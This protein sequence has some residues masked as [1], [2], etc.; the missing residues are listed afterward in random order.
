MTSW[1]APREGKKNAGSDVETIFLRRHAK[2]WIR[3]KAHGFNLKRQLLRALDGLPRQARLVWL[4]EEFFPMASN[5][6]TSAQVAQIAQRAQQNP[7]SVTPEEI[8][9]LAASV[10]N[11]QSDRDRQQQAQQRSGQQNPQDQ[12]RR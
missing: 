11:Q 4:V 7:K 10:L 1:P 6:K 12:Q 2:L 3:A 8:Q 5:E 9:A